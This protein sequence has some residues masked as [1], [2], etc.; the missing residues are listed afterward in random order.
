MLSLLRHHWSRDCKQGT[1][2]KEASPSTSWKALFRFGQA[3]P[4]APLARARPGWRSYLSPLA[5]DGGFSQGDLAMA[6]RS[7]N[8]PW[9]A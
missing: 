5:V 9:P 6:I 1:V 8:I 3:S 2:E 4:L 7:A